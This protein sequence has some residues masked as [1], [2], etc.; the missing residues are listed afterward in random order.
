M[1]VWA[2]GFI[3]EQ[4]FHGVVVT[5]TTLQAKLKVL[6]Q[7]ELSPKQICRGLKRAGYVFG[8]LQ[9]AGKWKPPAD[10]SERVRKFALEL[11]AAIKAKY[12]IVFD[13]VPGRIVLPHPSPR[14][15]RLAQETR[16]RVI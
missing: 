10:R 3:D 6:F 5:S 12:K 1:V 7:V 13:R 16:Q 14:Q 4:A 9:A 2:T 11:D 8:R 15:L